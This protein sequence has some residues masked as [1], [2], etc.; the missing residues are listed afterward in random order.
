MIHIRKLL[1]TQT[2]ALL[3]TIIYLR[4]IKTSSE[5]Q[6][7]KETE[8]NYDGYGHCYVSIVAVAACRSI[9]RHFWYYMIYSVGSCP[10]Y[11]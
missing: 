7:S 1:L 6:N 11:M 2:S 5:N 3:K 10:P 4:K 8:L 9:M